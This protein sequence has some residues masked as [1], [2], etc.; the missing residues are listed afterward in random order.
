MKVAVFNLGDKEYGLDITQVREVIR[1]R[2]I[3][4]I[5]DT[6]DFVE[7]VISLH[8]KVIP[9]V[10]LCVKLGMERT[11][12]LKTNRIIVIQ[13]NSHYIGVI[14]DGV[15]DVISTDAADINAPDE[16]LKEAVYLIGVIKKAQRLILIVDMAKLLNEDIRSQIQ[17]VHEKIQLR[18]K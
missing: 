14:V 12:L 4:P 1:L 6:A 8:G 15:T 13:I 3:T 2:A 18:Y 16:I 9:L 11:I 5:P 10:N 17:M 7:G